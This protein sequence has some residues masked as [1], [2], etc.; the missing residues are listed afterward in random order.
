MYQCERLPFGVSVAPCIFQSVMDGVLQ[1]LTGVCCFLDDIL[2]ST[3][4]LENYSIMLDTIL[5]RLEDH[6]ILAKKATCEFAVDEV[7]YLDH[8][9]NASCLKPKEEKIEAIT[10]AKIP[11]N[12]SELRTFLEVVSYYRN[13]FQIWQICIHH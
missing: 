8:F 13:L 11:T 1:G 7:V 6:N 12:V 2:I 3:D 9:I 4:T 10:N 5:K